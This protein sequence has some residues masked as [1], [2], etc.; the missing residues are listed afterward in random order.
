MAMQDIGRESNQS[1][2]VITHR[3]GNIISSGDTR[4]SSP[5]T[6]KVILRHDR[7]RMVVRNGTRMIDNGTA[8]GEMVPK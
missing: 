4:S 6:D 1:T 2:I 7:P 5:N 3:V 8:N